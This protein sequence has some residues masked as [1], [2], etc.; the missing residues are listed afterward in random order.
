ME[1][2]L[3]TFRFAQFRF[4]L[5]SLNS[6]RLP[7]YKGSTLRG[8]FGHAFKRVVCVNREKTCESCLLKGKC[9][10]SYVFETPPPSDTSRMRKYPFAPHPFIVTP[11]LEEKKEYRGGEPL[12]FGLT[13][14]GKAIDYLPYFIYTFD[15]LGKMGIGKG[16]GQ[17]E[18][19]E[20]RAINIGERLKVKGERE[21]TIYSKKD[22]ILHSSY[23]AVGMKD[24]LPFNLSPLTLNLLFLTP[25]RLK[26]DG[27]LTPALEFHILFRNL[28]RRISLL[29]YFHCGSELALDFKA[30]IEKAKGV[31]VK[32]ENLSWVDWERYSNRQETKMKMGGFVGSITFEGDVQPFLPFILL[33]EYVHVG[34]GTSFGLG[35]YEIVRP[36]N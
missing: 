29:S 15:E 7:V 14:V 1:G 12:C 17:Y 35:K 26:F 20:V 22:K 8:A 16:R 24:L 36:E 11:P 6:I 9:V 34:K 30:L 10:Y 27:R 13:L 31:K 5:K 23:K 18:L 32:N 25:T 4:L 2:S 33:G 19:E 21:E 3:S 28:L